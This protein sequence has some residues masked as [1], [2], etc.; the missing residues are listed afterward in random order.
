MLRLMAHG[1]RQPM[2]RP[3]TTQ[4]RVW[5]MLVVAGCSWAL[6]A[7]EQ[8]DRFSGG[9]DLDTPPPVI[10]G[11][12]IVRAPEP[13]PQTSNG[14]SNADGTPSGADANQ[15]APTVPSASPEPPALRSA[16][17]TPTAVNVAP[18]VAAVSS[19]GT[20][21]PPAISPASMVAP[22]A[23]VDTSRAPHPARERSAVLISADRAFASRSGCSEAVRLYASVPR[24]SDINGPDGTDWVT[25][26]LRT[27][28]CSIELREWTRALDAI[29]LV[30]ASRP[31]EWSAAYFEGHVYCQMGQFDRGTK[32]FRDLT[33]LMGTLGT[34]ARQAV[35]LLS[36]YGTATCDRLDYEASR[37]PERNKDQLEL[38]LGEYEEF[39][40][41]ADRIHSNGGVPTEYAREVSSALKSA[42]DNVTKYSKP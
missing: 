41:G 23:A 17:Q 4:S 27:A 40:K 12:M 15:S 2:I 24:P 26:Q 34:G 7:C 37:Q 9:I 14:A 33:S 30:K 11:T 28:Q 21:T 42:R 18:S 19:A 8:A 35:T 25:A 5:R 22:A 20:R 3:H 6:M 29:A 31:R 39:L 38:F 1:T 36:K 32:A 10:D 16:A 13:S